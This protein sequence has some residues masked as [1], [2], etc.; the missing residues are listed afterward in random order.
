MSMTNT[1]S[2]TTPMP[3]WPAALV[4]EDGSIFHGVGFGRCCESIAE[5]VFNTSLTGYQEIVSEPSYAGQIVVMTASQIGNVGCNPSDSEAGK[6]VCA[7]L[8]VR[9][10][11]PVVS[12]WRATTSL[13]QWLDDAGMPGIDEVDTRAIT[14]LLRTKGAMRGAITPH[15]HELDAVLARVKASPSM[16]G[17]DLVP[18]VTCAAAYEWQGAAAGSWQAADDGRAVPLMPER[19]HVVAYDFGIKENILRQLRD[20]GCKVTVVPATTTAEAALALGADGF[21][22]SNG[23]GDPA[24]VTY[25]IAATRGL[26][27]SGKPVFGI[28]LGHQILALALGAKT[29]KLP[30]GH[31]GGNHPVKDLVTNKVEITAQN[32]GFAVDETSLPAGTVV[33]H[34]NLFDQSVEGLAVT[35]QPVFSVQYHPEA[36]PGPHDSHYLFVRFAD[37]MLAARARV[38]A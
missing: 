1:P 27:A 11:S 24:A 30:F 35:G 28:C 23:P 25:G 16:D 36:S 5:I 22:L 6:A 2:T 33:S 18:R 29:Y 37:D 34:R 21:F 17:L 19:F 12:N 3:R 4:F 32:H 13:P 26:V 14:R 31:H 9:E 10:V 15:V 20:V 8:V 38:G 7:G